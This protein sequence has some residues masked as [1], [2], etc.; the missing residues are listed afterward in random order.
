MA[1]RPGMQSSEALH[2]R[3]WQIEILPVDAGGQATQALVI[4]HGELE[5]IGW[6]GQ[7]TFT[8][9]DLPFDLRITHAA[10]NATPIPVSAPMADRS[11][12]P[13]VDGF[14]LLQ[15][16]K[17][18]EAERNSAGFCAEFIPKNG[19][20]SIP[21]ILWAHIGGNFAPVKPF[22]LRTGGKT[23]AVQVV[24]E[25]MAIPFT[26][27]L[28]QFLFEKYA[29]VM[30]AKNYQS[31]ITKLEDGRE[32]KL[33]VKM[34]EPFRH[35]GYTFFQ[36]SFGPPDAGPD[37]ELYTVFTVWRNPSDHW[38]LISLVVTFAGLLAH[39]G[40][41]LAEHLRRSTRTA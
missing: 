18:K 24:R 38:P 23:F 4:P 17:E 19:D 10:R 12:S 33:E 36:A 31:N 20:P 14:K 32:E 40:W 11:D 9:P 1:L 34:N 7:R 2:Y 28:D 37:D 3:N 22:T 15:L 29:G 27:R 21:A 13:E 8:T 39:M 16:P 41:K 30:T 35:R 5:S 25:R 6:K 26:I